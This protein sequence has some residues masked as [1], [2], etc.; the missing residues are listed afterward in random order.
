[1]EKHLLSALLATTALLPSHAWAAGDSGENSVQAGEIVVTANKREQNLNDVGLTVAVLSG[2]VLKDRQVNSLADLAQTIPS[3][4]FSSTVSNTP[5][6]TLRGVG[7]NEAS[8]GAY[9]TVSVYADE[10]PL[11]FPVLASHS[12]YDLERVEVLKGPQ[13]TLFGQN[14]TGGAINYIVAKP[15][16]EFQAGADL[17]YGRF[18][19][20]IG[21]GFVSGP[22]SDTLAARLSGRFE[23]ADG[24]QISNSRPD[25]R[26]GEVENYMGRLQ[27]AFEPSGGMRFLLNVNGWVD[28]S[29][30]LA[31]QYIGLTPQNP[32][33]DPQVELAPFSPL[34]PRAA[35]WTDG[36][37]FADNWMWQSSFRADIDLS[38]SLTLTSLTSYTD[39]K[40][41]Q[42]VDPDGLPDRVQQLDLNEGDIRNFSQ[43]IRI[44]NGGSY[45]LRWVVGGNYEHSKVNESFFTAIPDSS[46]NATLGAVF[47]YPITNATS[48]VSQKLTNFAFF[49]N[50]E[51]DVISNVTAKAGVRYTEAKSSATSCNADLTGNP[52]DSGA[53]FYD[54]L[55]G[56]AFGAYQP[57]DCFA[58]N[59]QPAAVGDVQPGAPGAF[60]GSLREDNISWRVGL[61]WKPQPDILLYANVAKGY[62]AGSFATLSAFVFSQYAPVTQESVLSYEAGLKASLLGRTLQVNGA[63]F[64][65]DYKGKQLRSK[66]DAGPFGILDQLQNVPK[67]TVKGFELEFVA[68]PIPNLTLSSNF[69]YLDAKIDEFSG[70]N[71]GGVQADFA[72]TDIPYT[73]KYQVGANVDYTFPLNDGL[74]GFIGSSLTFRSSTSAVIG[75]DLNPLTLVASALNGAPVFEIKDYVLVDLRAG[76]ETSDGRWRFSAWGK[77]IFNEYYLQDVRANFDVV[78]RNAGKPATYGVS[79]GFRY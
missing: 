44:S 32:I 57:G 64:Y 25:D 12:A 29:E 61:D 9:P 40:K 46:S 66:F 11:T 3:L 68:Q 23:R 16:G 77:N 10:V 4:T 31:S 49:G 58:I 26:N 69:T 14:A 79:L 53:F 73:P 37:P 30:P 22:L 7:F 24:W 63:A 15:T 5:V 47:G 45:D 43:E 55:L 13:G 72:G 70:I 38:D 56:G 75:G 18:N 54:I 42:G 35:D 36:T 33:L 65:Y 41:R 21:E 28:K 39:Y 1:M 17:S 71:P 76:V 6:F 74:D 59:D 78:D 2:D 52:N 48:S 27:L 50:I 60:T 20:V 19:E 62:K 8:L 67:S 51:Y 34:T